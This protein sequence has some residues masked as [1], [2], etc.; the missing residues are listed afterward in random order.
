MSLVLSIRSFGG[1]LL[2]SDEHALSTPS[3]WMSV[4]ISSYRPVGRFRHV[5]SVKIMTNHKPNSLLY[6]LVE[7]P[8]V[9]FIPHTDESFRQMRLSANALI[10]KKNSARKSNSLAIETIRMKAGG[11][12][13]NNAFSIFPK[14][15]SNAKQTVWS[16]Y[17][18]RGNCSKDVGRRTLQW[19]SRQ[20][21]GEIS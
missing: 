4:I 6:I 20:L 1:K 12:K 19:P 10:L 14:S 8:T 15:D 5:N 16:F 17:I 13:L 2:L 21:P 3:R 7:S 11:S 18:M 9:L